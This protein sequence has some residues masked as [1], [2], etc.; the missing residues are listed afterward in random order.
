M[1]NGVLIINYINK[2]NQFEKDDCWLE[3]QEQNC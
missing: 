2:E 1:T 3:K